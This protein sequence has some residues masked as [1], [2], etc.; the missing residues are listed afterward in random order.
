MAYEKQTWNTGDVITEE[1]LNHMEDGIAS[2]G[3]GGGVLIVNS[4]YDESTETAIL[5]KTWQE[6]YDAVKQKTQVI[7][8]EN[9]FETDFGRIALL[10]VT[11]VERNPQK[12]LVTV[13]SYDAIGSAYGEIRFSSTAAGDYPSQE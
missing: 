8:E 7:I 6:I 12:Y 10:P 13:L 4:N 2:G 1:K 11:S 9:T 3:S 5:D